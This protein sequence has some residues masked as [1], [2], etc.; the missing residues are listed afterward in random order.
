MSPCQICSQAEA[1]RG[2]GLCLDCGR[3]QD[4]WQGLNAAEREHEYEM[5][6]AYAEASDD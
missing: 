2:D 1:V 5:M 4:Y 3:W 6:A